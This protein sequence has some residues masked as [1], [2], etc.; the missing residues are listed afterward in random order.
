MHYGLGVTVASVPPDAAAAIRAAMRGQVD[1]CVHQATLISLR[2]HFSAS[3]A[4]AS[5]R[6][7]GAGP[8]ADPDARAV[9]ARRTAASAAHTCMSQL[10]RLATARKRHESAVR[11][12]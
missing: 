2:Q 12:P 7:G 8:G 10:M 1:A 5:R 9:A 6:A 4:A 3:A 11:Q